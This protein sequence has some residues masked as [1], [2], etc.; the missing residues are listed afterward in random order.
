MKIY[1]PWAFKALKYFL[2]I[3]GIL[4]VLTVLLFGGVAIY[5]Y[6]NQSHIRDLVLS[7]LNE[8]QV[9]HTTLDKVYINPYLEFPYIAVDL[10]Q[11]SFYSTAQDLKKPIYTFEDVY[12]GF[13]IWDIL[14]GKYDIKRI[15]ARNG[16]INLVK[17]KNG[18]YNLLLA[19]A[20]K[21]NTPSA[22]NNPLQ[23]HLRRIVLENITVFKTD[24]GT[25]QY[26]EVHLRQAQ[27][28]LSYTSQFIKNNLE[29]NLALKL[30]QQNDLV[31]FKNKN[32]HLKT[33][34]LFDLPKNLLT[35]R[36]SNFEIEGAEFSLAGSVDM[37]K[38][39][40]VDLDIQGKKPDFKLI[41][42]FAPSDVY[43]KLKTYQNKGNIYFRGKVVGA[44]LDDIPQIDLEFGCK[45]AEFVNP[46]AK[47][48]VRDLNFAGFFTNG[49]KKDLTTCELQIKSLSG[50]PEESIFKG[51]FHIKNFLNPYISIDFHSKLDLA[52]LQNFYPNENLK[53]LKGWLIVDMTIDELLDYNDVQGSLGKLKDGTDS[54]VI[55]KDVSFQPLAYPLPIE[56]IQA[57][58][59][60]IAG[61]LVMNYL[62]AQIKQNDIEI[63]GDI[64]NLAAY[65]HRQPADLTAN[66]AIKA[67]QLDLQ[68][69][70]SFDKKMAN[71]YAEI[72][73]NL[74]FKAAFKTKAE[75]LYK[76]V[77]IPQGEFLIEELNLKL[78]NYPH[79]IHDTHLDFIISQNDIEI[80]RLESEIDKSDLHLLGKLENYHALF[81]PER[82][83][84][85]FKLNLNFKAN[86]LNFKDLLTY[87]QVNY[88]PKDYQNEVIQNLM[89]DFDLQMAAN[90]LYSGKFEQATTLD[91]K[92][93]DC[94]LQQHPLQLREFGGHFDLKNNILTLQNFR[95]KLG[96]SDFSLAGTID[97]LTTA[98]D[99]KSKKHLQFKANNLNINELIDYQ[100]PTP[101]QDT[102]P[103]NH[104]AGFNLFAIPFPDLALQ[105][106]IGKLTYK[107]YNL[108]QLSADLRITQNHYIYVDNLIMNT[109][110]GSVGMKGYFNGE[111]KN[112]IYL[113][114]DL[115]IK[116]LD[117]DRVFV[118][119]DNFGQDY[120]LSKNLHGNLTAK[121]KSK[122]LLHT[123]LTPNLQDTEA[124]IEGTVKNGRMVNF[125][126]FQ[127]MSRFFADK[128]MNDIRF[129]ELSNTFD[130][131]NGKIS[132]PRMEISTNLGF[133]Y[134]AGSQ[135]LNQTM[136]YVVEVP[137]KLIRQAAWSYFFKRRRNEANVKVDSDTEA[138]ISSENS[139][140]KNFISI[141]LSGTPE[142][143][144]V[145]LGK[146][147]RG[148]RNE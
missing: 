38:K 68:E 64:D 35:I 27:T 119:F 10:H 96:Q 76:A 106:Q 125:A 47:S 13:S 52:T 78:N 72:I 44:C 148:A 23:I 48:S 95:G 135:S 43:E 26:V 55:L 57:D 70:L 116:N 113:S 140:F 132:F 97:N 56:K 8:N 63:L 30:L 87:K 81:H 91:L 122:V 37:N 74:T 12:L 117:L 121:I 59:R 136:D 60:I 86:Q 126:P 118:K 123:D 124:H 51:S 50:K 11:L 115:D 24:L 16:K 39:A 15:T 41:T 102:I 40:F 104:D 32:I 31:L 137:V 80:K 62:R 34:I 42:A 77:D 129:G 89:L 45:N 18:L 105:A 19:K 53:S 66:L 46:K 138:I 29:A 65:F 20:S 14:A 17:D 82:K 61:K 100:I 21:K 71:D 90:D 145:R 22:K 114:G 107:Q 2:W 103:K 6:R 130:F 75:Y 134:V 110:G 120:L 25:Q 5:L 94:K 33:D 128:D 141:H 139:N 7:T 142:N 144:K 54:R 109:A 73:R 143:Y 67:K 146:G 4:L 79:S 1:H 36:P 88:L 69:L 131:K 112:K 9:G 85:V 92:R 99:F 93:L 98:A 108:E 133:I 83:Q 84:E 127:M 3:F 101:A 28:G 147:K 49:A 58:V 111:N